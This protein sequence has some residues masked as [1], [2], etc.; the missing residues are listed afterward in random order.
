MEKSLIPLSLVLVSGPPGVGK[1]TLSQKLVKK[2][3]L[4]YLDKDL[5]DEPFSPGERG[6]NYT[7]NIE[8][9]VLESILGLSKANLLL[10]NSVLVD[11]PWSHILH[12]SPGLIKSIV[13]LT[14]ETT[15]LLKVLECSLSEDKHFK[16]MKSRNLDRDQVKLTEKGWKDFLKRDRVGELIPFKHRLIDLGRDIDIEDIIAYLSSDESSI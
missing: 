3:N 9:K 8:P 4:F 14:K 10:G 5:I 16:R 13:S 12:D 6:D 1:S 15:S 7:K 11:L 2:L